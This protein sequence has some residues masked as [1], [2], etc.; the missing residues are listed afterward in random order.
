[1]GDAGSDVPAVGAVTVMMVFWKVN[2]ENVRW[3]PSSV[4]R[5]FPGIITSVLEWS[6]RYNVPCILCKFFLTTV[7]DCAPQRWASYYLKLCLVVC[8]Q[9][10]SFSSFFILAV[11]CRAVFSNYWRYIKDKSKIKVKVLL[12]Q[13]KEKSSKRVGHIKFERSL[14]KNDNNNNKIVQVA[15]TKMLQILLVK[16]KKK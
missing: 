10:E 12:P 13:I 11:V 4:S 9:A 8:F 1:M 5:V 6:R 7:K 3:Y 16:R 14:D 15:Q 2:A